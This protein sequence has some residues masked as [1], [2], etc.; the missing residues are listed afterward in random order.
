MF[1]STREEL[2]SISISIFFAGLL[3]CWPLSVRNKSLQSHYKTLESQFKGYLSPYFMCAHIS[4]K[5][6]KKYLNLL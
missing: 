3:Y 4:F 2:L 1:Y 5:S 6:Y